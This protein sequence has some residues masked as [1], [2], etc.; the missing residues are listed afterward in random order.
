MTHNLF[1]TLNK[2]TFSV[3]PEGLVLYG[4]SR[5]HCVDEVVTSRVAESEPES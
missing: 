5:G 4:S 1:I 3:K 2:T